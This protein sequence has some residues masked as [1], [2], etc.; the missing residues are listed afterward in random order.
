ME[1]YYVWWP[2]LTSKRV[3]QVCQHQLSFLLQLLSHEPLIVAILLSVKH[4]LLWRKFVSA[5]ADCLLVILQ[6]CI[7]YLWLKYTMCT[8]SMPIVV[9][10]ITLKVVN[11]FPLNLAYSISGECLE[12]RHKNYLLH[13]MYIC[14]KNHNCNET[15][16]NFK[17]FFTK[18]SWIKTSTI[19]FCSNLH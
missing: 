19:F 9:L 15:W 4:T 8:E 11:I 7:N 18:Y 5:L 2:W 14:Y 3:V 13:L 6:K 17:L 1:W 10:T 16:H 12:M